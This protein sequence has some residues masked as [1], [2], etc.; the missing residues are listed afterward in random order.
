MGVFNNSATMCECLTLVVITPQNG[1]FN[2]LEHLIQ[3]AKDF[4][5]M[6][7]SVEQVLDYHDRYIDYWIDMYI[8][9][10]CE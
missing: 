8:E 10:Y 3:F 7:L 9:S 6:N 1:V 2:N 5:L 4:K